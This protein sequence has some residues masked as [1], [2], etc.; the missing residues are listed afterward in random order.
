[1]ARWPTRTEHFRAILAERY[2]V[3]S[4]LGR[5]DLRTLAA[6][7]GLFEDYAC[8]LARSAGYHVYQESPRVEPIR[9]GQRVYAELTRVTPSEELAMI[10]RAMAAVRRVE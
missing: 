6:E 5:A 2:P 10:E 9:G 4:R 3:G 1:M 7:A 8:N